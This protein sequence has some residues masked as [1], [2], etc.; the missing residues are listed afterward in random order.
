MTRED[1]EQE[2]CHTPLPMTPRQTPNK[3][4]TTKTMY[5]YFVV[6]LHL[7]SKLAIDLFINACLSFQAFLNITGNSSAA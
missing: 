7:Y 4:V 3:P 2:G 6:A 1:L 5:E